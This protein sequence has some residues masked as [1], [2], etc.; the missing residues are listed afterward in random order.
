MWR[1]L[2]PGAWSERKEAPGAQGEMVRLKIPP[3]DEKE[4]LETYLCRFER[5]AKLQQWDLST[6][7]VRL[8]VLLR[9]KA[10]EVYI[11]LSDSDAED[12]QKLKTAL[13]A[14]FRLTAE[15]YRRKLRASRREGGETFRQYVARIRLYLARWIE[16]A[17][18]AA[19]FEGMQDLVLMKQLLDSVPL[20]LATFIRERT[21]KDVDDAA[22]LAQQLTEA[23][24]AARSH[25][26]HPTTRP[27]ESEQQEK[28]SE[29]RVKDDKKRENNVCFHCGKEGHF[30]KECPKLHKS[31]DD[32]VACVSLNGHEVTAVR[33]TGADMLCV[34]RD[35]VDKKDLTNR[36]RKRDTGSGI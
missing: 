8:G 34:R 17:G 3:F 16:L 19:T 9:G 28:L 24:E 33:D 36:R 35:L 21:P 26:A 32:K 27:Q 12:Y 7:A 29:P 14:R 5:W 18:K 22:T 25:R 30:R 13:L 1:L 6:W 31:T 20:D 11:G 15:S 4:D 23:R 2:V 10:S